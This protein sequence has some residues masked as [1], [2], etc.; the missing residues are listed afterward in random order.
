MK[1]P[2]VFQYEFIE[3][4]RVKLTFSGATQ[5]RC[6]KKQDWNRFPHHRPS[7][8]FEIECLLE[9]KDAHNNA[10]CESSE[11]EC[12]N[13]KSFKNRNKQFKHVFTF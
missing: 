11:S 10:S 12:V 5:H 6:Y 13:F 4:L 8:C 1:N 3:F 2:A 7:F 9:Y